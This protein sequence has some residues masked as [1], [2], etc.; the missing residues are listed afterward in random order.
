MVAAVLLQLCVLDTDTRACREYSKQYSTHA[1]HTRNGG[2][3]DTRFPTDQGRHAGYDLPGRLPAVSGPAH[4]L[5][6][7]L[8]FE[9]C[10]PSRREIRSF[11][12][13]LVPDA[14]LKCSYG[15][16]RFGMCNLCT[17]REGYANF[18]IRR[19]TRRQM[20][21][22]VT[23]LIRT[24]ASSDPNSAIHMRVASFP[25]PMNFARILAA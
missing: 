19:S 3:I 20:C 21:P 23:N 5:R 14:S 6:D 8:H 1:G 22:I 10:A 13:L 9:E 15:L 25:P 24:R 4:C 2:R 17:V 12:K 16:I 11:I 7:L 18:K